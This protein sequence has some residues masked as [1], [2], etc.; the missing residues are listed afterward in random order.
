MDFANSYRRSWPCCEWA[1]PA[2]ILHLYATF[3]NQKDHTRDRLKEI[4]NPMRKTNSWMLREIEQQPAVLEKILRL[5]AA[6]VER[7]AGFL[8]KREIHS[9]ILVA[10][11]TSDNAALF[12]RYLI[13]TA[14]SYPVSLAAPSIHTLY[15]TRLRL[16]KTLTI[17]VSQSGAGADINLVLRNCKRQGSL[18]VGITNTPNSEMAHIVDE[19]FPVHAGKERSVAATKT[20]TGQ[21]LLFYLL[22]GA[23]RGRKLPGLEEIPQHAAKALDLRDSLRSIVE[24]YRF[25]Q[26]CIVIGRGLNYAN[27][28]E[29]SLK[30][31]ETCYVVAKG[32]SAADFFHGPIAII[33]PD[34][35]IFLWMPPGKTLANMLLLQRRLRE[36]R[37]ETVVV[38]GVRAALRLAATSLPMPPDIDDFHS[39]IPYIIPGQLFAAM[40][41]EAKGLSPDRPRGLQ[42]VT[43]TI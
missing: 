24:R 1:K 41:A 10:R 25:M 3:E 14:T 29:F 38:S 43:K 28:L 2:S 15:K 31:M 7:F 23:L 17:G 22:A 34:F 35:P 13:E 4:Q 19:V 12:G 6:R 37:A 30:L 33:E 21:L 11:G 39:V 5:E 27:A 32:Y 20:Y 26:R 16:E 8:S 40:L 42:K 18:V 9:V 36:L